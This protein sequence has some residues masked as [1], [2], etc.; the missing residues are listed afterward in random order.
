M[1]AALVVSLV[2][3]VAPPPCTHGQ[4]RVTRGPENG[5]A[6]QLHWPVRFRNASGQACSLRGFPVVW[7]VTGPHGHRIGTRA[8]PDRVSRAR[9]VR[10]AAGGG[11]A[12]AVFT[13]T[14]VGVFDP[15][16]CHPRLARGIRVTP[17]GQTGSFFVRLA[18]HV[19]STAR[20]SGSDSTVRA[21][22]RGST[23]L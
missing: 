20:P 16:S 10:L 7:S 12:S 23:G 22:V 2:A 19:C 14:D 18:H 15:A 3:A 6:G 13:Q 11:I 5:S 9:R 17:P 4:L 8:A 21:I 1:L